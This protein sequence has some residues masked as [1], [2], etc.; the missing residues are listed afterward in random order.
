MTTYDLCKKFINAK[1]YSK[2]EI[3]KRVDT[4][5]MFNR[6]TQE[7]YEELTALVNATYDEDVA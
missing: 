2:A 7:Q 1:T 3:Q 5:Y 6:L 4:F